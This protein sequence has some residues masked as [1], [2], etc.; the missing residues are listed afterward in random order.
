MTSDRHATATATPLVFE[1]EV[2]GTIDTPDGPVDVLR[3]IGSGL[4]RRAG[5]PPDRFWAIGD[6]GPN[7][8]ARPAMK[9]FGLKHVA[10]PGD[11]NAIKVMP[12]PEIGPAISE[13]RLEQNR[14]VCVRTMALRGTSGRP[15]SGLP[16]PGG[17]G[18]VAI[19]LDGSAIAPDPSGADT[20][21]I[22]ALADG[23]FWVSDEY[24]PSLFRVAPDGMVLARWVP[25]GAEARFAGAD[26][27]VLDILPAIA[28]QRQF[29]R[30]FEALALSID[31]AW[32][33]VA[34]QSPLAHPDIKA[35]KRGRHVRLWKLDAVTGDVAA[36]FLYPFD[37]PARFRRDTAL[38]AFD[39]SDLKLSE[40]VAL[41][42][43]LLLVLERGSATGKLYAVALEP[44]CAVAQ[45]HLDVA[46]RPTLEQLSGSG[47]S[48]PALT[49]RL[50]LTTDDL[51]QIDPDLEG[52]A[53]LSPRSLLL[54]NDNDFGIDG[55]R[56]RFWRIDLAE[57]LR[58]DWNGA[59]VDARQMARDGC[60][61]SP[62]PD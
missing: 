20:E 39:W 60:G 49:K 35:H 32:L 6:R 28:A 58:R 25:Q 43:D 16:I 48:L 41:G 57:D 55:A 13:L 31:E 30:G 51:P 15:L 47:R 34:F 14:M 9:R 45:V 22:A 26:Y 23:G 46:T 4:A 61:S 5:D 59:A 29:N 1:D 53:V 8:N 11:P 44:A 24:G 37:E 42:P 50:I 54:V 18:E 21:G 38:G 3:G 36:Q 40:M 62:P 27:P 19:G 56:T 10:H 52:V 2:L 17:A 12:C 33:Y 7:L